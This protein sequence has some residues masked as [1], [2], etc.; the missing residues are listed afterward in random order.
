MIK[1]SEE[2]KVQLHMLSVRTTS[3]IKDDEG[4]TD[5]KIIGSGT[6]IG[7]GENCYVMTAGHCINSLNKDQIII[8][9]YDGNSFVSLDIL[10]VISC[11]Y[12][13]ETG[14]DYALL[15][16]RPP[17]TN[18]DYTSII[19]RFDLTI[20]EDSYF[21]LSYPP[22]AR[23]GRIF[24]V[25]NNINGHWEVSAEV[26]YSQDD[27]KDIINGSSGSGIFVYRHNRFYYV[28][29]VV[30]TRDN[31]GRFND[32]KALKPN[33]FD[34]IIPDDTKDNDYFDTL[35][36]WE[37]WNDEQNEKERREIVRNQNVEW[38]DNLIRKAKVLFPHNYERKV[39]I[40]IKYYIK[41]MGI[42]AKMLESN[43]SFVGELN[44]I[45]DR[46]FEKKVDIHKEYFDSSDGAYEDL[47]GI[48]DEIKNNTACRF[49]EDKEGL[50]SLN[51][52]LYRVVERLLN[53]HLD[54]KQKV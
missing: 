47:K 18:M 15:L 30:A 49:P 45:N 12:K 7:S 2:N 32:I 28:G 19:K 52:A 14:E 40:Y 23:D 22:S 50:I 34:G 36:T 3:I 39:D 29:L 5:K 20:P 48:I 6:I 16:V 54:Y 42:L 10:E 26:N 53:C 24:E 4:G 8:E 17:K 51:Y 33:V 13:P 44:K 38:L 27:F 41:G 35:R 1:L 11:V 43:P 25:K 37:D 21:M 31:I 9:C 46:Y